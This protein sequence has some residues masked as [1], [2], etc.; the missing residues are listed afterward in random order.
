MS[1][2]N[3]DNL[4]HGSFFDFFI[5]LICS[6]QRN[7]GWYSMVWGWAPL[8]LSRGCD[9]SKCALL[10]KAET[11]V[12]PGLGLISSVYIEPIPVCFPFLLRFEQEQWLPPGSMMM[13]IYL[14]EPSILCLLTEMLLRSG[15]SS[16]PTVWKV[17]CR[18]SWGVLYLVVPQW[19]MPRFPQPCASHQ[20]LTYC[21]Q[22]PENRFSEVWL[23]KGNAMLFVPWEPRYLGSTNTWTP[24]EI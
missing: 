22:L 16:I 4:P 20:L 13:L 24:K 1:P 17:S 8:I 2:Q 15:L 11:W 9:G 6:L 7:F 18:S 14:S 3:E 5:K 19:K 21:E 23:W 12:H 10:C